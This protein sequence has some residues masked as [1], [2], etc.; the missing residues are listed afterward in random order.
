MTDKV[1]E[2]SEIIVEQPQ[3]QRENITHVNPWIRLI[4]RFVDYSLFFLLLL[5][6][7]L[8][9]NDHLPFGKY[10][11]LVPFEFFVWIPIEALLLSTW[12]TTPGKF[13][14]K[15]KLKQGKKH[16]LEYMTAL[17]RSFSVWIRGLGLGIPVL[18]F[19]C[20]L[21]A[22]NK[23]RLLQITSWD[24]DDHIVVTHYPIGR[25][26]IYIAVFV[27]A[28]GILYYYSEKNSELKYVSSRVVRSIDEYPLS[29]VVTTR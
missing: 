25:W 11:H 13:F 26:R 9:F 18:N 17:K 10:E 15:T 3:K 16:K 1:V 22:Y 23:L 24:R 12:G 5:S 4:A 7:R 6:S 28:S 20:L 27:A 14:L 8:L 19:F 21:I 29:Q 2:P